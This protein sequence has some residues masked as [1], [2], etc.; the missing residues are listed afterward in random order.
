MWQDISLHC[1]RP[2]LLLLAGLLSLWLAGWAI[3]LDIADSKILFHTVAGLVPLLVN[4]TFV[5]IIWNTTRYCFS[6]TALI[7]SLSLL[8]TI[9]YGIAYILSYPG[10][11]MPFYVG[12]DAH[13]LS[14]F[15]LLLARLSL[16][17]GFIFAIVLPAA[18][19]CAT[20][21]I[22]LLHLSIAIFTLGVIMAAAAFPEAIGAIEHYTITL[23]F[24]KLNLSQITLL[25]Y[26]LVALALYPHR[27][28]PA[29]APH[30]KLALIC[31]ILAEL[32][33]CSYRPSFDLLIAMNY[34]FQTL[35]GIFLVRGLFYNAID[36]PY[37]NII[38][39]K[40]EIE[41]LAQSHATMYEKARQ[42][43]ALLE[44]TFARLGNIMSSRLDLDE[45][46]T[47]IIDMAVGMVDAAQGILALTCQHPD[48]LQVTAVTG[49][50]APPD[51]IPLSD[52]LAGRVLATKTAQ[53]IDDISACPEL[54]RP[55]LLFSTIMSAL[56]API[57]DDNRCLGVLEVYSPATGAFDAHDALLL[58]A[59]GRHAG[60][61]I[62]GAMLYEETK[63]RLEEEQFLL[64][65]SQ[66]AAKS[67]DGDTVLM[68]GTA[69]MRRA[70][71]ADMA[72]GFRL[73]DG[74]LLPVTN[75]DLDITL[76]SLKLEQYPALAAAL[77]KKKPLE[78]APATFLPVADLYSMEKLL[79]FKAVP[80]VVDQRVLG[81]IILGWQKYVNGELLKRDSFTM[82]MAQ[83]IS[84]GLEKADL[85]AQIR[86]MALS[87]GLTGLANR[88]NF[89]MFLR[90]ELRRAASLRRPLSLIICDL[91]K[92]KLYNDKYGH[93][94]GDK[95]LTQIGVILQ[96]HV[97]PIDLPARYGGEEFSIILPE[98]SQTEAIAL[99]EKIRQAV[100]NSAFPDAQGALTAR[101]TASLGVAAYDP[102]LTPEPPDTT[103][104][105]AMADQALYQAKQ[106]GRNK[107]VA[108]TAI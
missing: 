13:S 66:T 82:L 24:M 7:L 22:R 2:P 95:L 92:F 54:Y 86:S 85:Y 58:T 46:M 10:M 74:T 19:A 12:A 69:L 4:F 63:L 48:T 101:I 18:P 21:P 43:Q 15:Y 68:E 53:F 57:M 91:D 29:I 59:I 107:V 72:I 61:A 8:A 80:L 37:L 78:L 55:K 94:T 100:E 33:L 106:T 32:S 9:M 41:L 28:D 36:K 76:P 1:R 98:C 47:N 79:Q 16:A 71:G 108:Y 105:I 75:H 20:T 62:A 83:Q 26:A 102:A 60:A 90:A 96:T 40:E 104:F 5:F 39:V 103:Q 64:Q 70:L 89:D 30:L 56:A 84:L 49:I 97:R 73:R 52:S 51:F 77:T 81:A 38:Q 11:P 44:D 99:A 17:V 27:G 3:P 25:L 23:G 50:S 87:D 31:Q 14:A 6:R 67:L 35:S 88:R 93:T 45:T 42:Q 65:V 34:G